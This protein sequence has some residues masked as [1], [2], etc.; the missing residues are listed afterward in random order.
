MVTIKVSKQRPR[1][2]QI[3]ILLKTVA[4]IIILSILLYTVV[5][6]SLMQIYTTSDVRLMIALEIFYFYKS[7]D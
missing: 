3:Q 2:K 4:A 5:S 6:P 1:I 7:I